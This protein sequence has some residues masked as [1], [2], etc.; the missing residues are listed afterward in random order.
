MWAYVPCSYE[1]IGIDR[2]D[3]IGCIC[4]PLGDGIRVAE[5][6][7]AKCRVAASVIGQ[8]PSDDGRLVGIARNNELHIVEEFLPDAHIGVKFVMCL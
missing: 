7:S 6:R 8:F 1:V 2:T 5:F 4:V 3:V